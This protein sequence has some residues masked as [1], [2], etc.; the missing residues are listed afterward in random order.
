MMRLQ[1]RTAVTVG[2]LVPLGVFAGAVAAALVP[3]EAAVGPVVLAVAAA[4]G[5]AAIWLTSRVRTTPAVSGAPDDGWAGF[6]L[7]LERA[8][9]YERS[10]ALV[11][12]G[13]ANGAASTDEPIVERVRAR[14]RQVDHVWQDGD[15][16]YV[17][18]PEGAPTAVENLIDRLRASGGLD[19]ID[20]RS[21]VFPDNAVTA[22]ALLG[23]IHDGEWSPV[24][25][26]LRA[27]REALSTA[28]VEVDLPRTAEDGHA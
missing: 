3:D 13:P 11:R 25:L 2:V 15:A 9:R 14:M 8:R 28:P 27:A 6:M 12:I 7:E 18:V 22:G 23:V 1:D 20:I 17:V 10:L 4:A 26:P 19:G 21:A 5:L 16:V 24:P